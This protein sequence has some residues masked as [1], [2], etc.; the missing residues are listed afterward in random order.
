MPTLDITG[1]TSGRNAYEFRASAP[2]GESESKLN[3]NGE[4]SLADT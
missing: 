2:I 4:F 3:G 1:T